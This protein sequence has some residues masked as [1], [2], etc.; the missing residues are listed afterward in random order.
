MS[1]VQLQVSTAFCSKLPSAAHF[2]LSTGRVSGPGRLEGSDGWLKTRTSNNMDLS[3]PALPTFCLQ[4][5]PSHTDM[6]T[7]SLSHTHLHTR[8]SAL[9]LL[10][11]LFKTHDPNSSAIWRN[12]CRL[13]LMF[14][15]FSFPV[16]LFIYLFFSPVSFLMPD[17]LGTAVGLALCSWK[18]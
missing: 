13:N 14:F 3:S 5:A 7:P 9:Q 1:S 10:W 4:P 11:L 18:K 2:W 17:Y 16:C 12:D 15:A 6:H 8:C